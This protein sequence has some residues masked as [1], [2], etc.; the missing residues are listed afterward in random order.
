MADVSMTI[1]GLQEVQDLN[2]RLIAAM[3]PSGG[4]GRA[5]KYATTEAHRYAVAITHVDTGALRASHRMEIEGLRGIISIDPTAK[6]PRSKALTSEYGVV[7]HERGG[8][9]AFYERTVKERG[10]KI[11]QRAARFVTDGID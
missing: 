6:N 2:I 5:V 7:E 8:Q 10:G 3:K 4:L 9:H 11:S 1:T